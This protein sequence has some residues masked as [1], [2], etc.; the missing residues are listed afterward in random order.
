MSSDTPETDAAQ[1]EGLLRT[2]PIPMQVVTAN[3]ARKLER[4]R[5]E[6][7]AV[8]GAMADI[9]EGSCSIP[10]WDSTRTAQ[11]QEAPAHLQL[12]DLQEVAPYKSMT[13]K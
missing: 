12:P 9:A 4:E 8:A 3:F 6:A 5:D 13:T 10:P 2:N 11:P 1:H 7:R